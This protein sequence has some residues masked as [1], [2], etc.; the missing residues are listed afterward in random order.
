[1]SPGPPPARAGRAGSSLRQ[2]LRPFAFR[3]AWAAA[4]LVTVVGAGAVGYA[5]IE[6]WGWFD[7]LYMSV[8]TVASVGFMEVRPLSD[9]GRAFTMVLIVLGVT[10]LGIWWGLITSLIVE[11]DLLGLL[12]SRRTMRALNQLSN[13]FI[14]CGYGRMGRVVVAEMVA[15]RVPF[16][17]IDSNPQRIAALHE[18]FSDALTLED[19]ATKEG[20]LRA[21]GIERARGLAA[22]LQDDADNLLLSLTACGLKRDLTIVARAYDEENLDKL[23][24]AGAHVAIS[25]NVTGAIRMASALLRPSVVSFLD[26]T[27]RGTDIDLRLEEATIP[28]ASALAGQ[29]LAQARIPQQTG[30]IVLA[31]RR[32]G[33]TQAFLY[34]PGPE[35]RLESGDVLIVLGHPEQVGALREFVAGATG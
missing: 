24:R 11:L 27:T 3:F 7:A 4:Y 34:N 20:T 22:C 17:A 31:V 32:A 28:A 16:V 30:L 35:T 29:S 26:V 25:P 2:A 5:L 8:T 13:H 19:D 1:M 21:A 14:V 6:G 12:R 33:G 23:T 10:G 18:R 15:A 9:T